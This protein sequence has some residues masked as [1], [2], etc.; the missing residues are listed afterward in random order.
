MKS[1]RVLGMRAASDGGLFSI[2]CGLALGVPGTALAAR[3]VISGSPATTVN[4]GQRYVFK[5]T[6]SDA[7]GDKLAFSITGLPAWAKFSTTYGSLVGTPKASH[8]GKWSN[9][10][11]RVSD[12]TTTRSLPVF[13]ITV[14]AGG[15]TAPKISG[16]PADTAKIGRT[17]SF[18]PTASDA[19]GQ[20]LTFAISNKPAWASFDAATGRLSG[21]PLKPQVGLYSGIVIIASD[22]QASTSLT[23]FSVKVRD[24]LATLSWAAPTSNVDGTPL[25]DLAGYRIVYGLAPGAL[26]KTLTINSPA[27]TS[28][29]IEDLAPGTW[30]FAVKSYTAASV[31]SDVS[32]MAQKTL[33]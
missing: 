5:P 15:N 12:G 30:Y 2:V 11:I 31:E 24:H 16:T 18:L 9:I 3:P 23:P 26:T 28:A 7:D 27:I 17:Y 8:A 1:K 13:S 6:A 10:R 19:D 20:K 32:N 4:A 25:I 14:V 33:N 21:V 29:M 22:G